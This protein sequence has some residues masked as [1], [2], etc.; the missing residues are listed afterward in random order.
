MHKYHTVSDNTLK[1]Y[2]RVCRF[3]LLV[4]GHTKMYKKSNISKI[5]FD[6]HLSLLMNFVPYFNLL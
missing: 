2:T 4:Y 5:L 3:T 6:I 1:L